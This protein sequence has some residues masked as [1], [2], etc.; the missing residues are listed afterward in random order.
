MA[1]PD[2]DDEPALKYPRQERPMMLPPT[3]PSKFEPP[4]GM[5]AEEPELD[6]GSTDQMPL[7]TD[8]ELNALSKEG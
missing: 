2:H 8:P 7:P 3:L 1:E 4:T 6:L 5:P